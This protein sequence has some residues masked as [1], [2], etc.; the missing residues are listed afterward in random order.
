MF[1][2]VCRVAWF[3]MFAALCSFLTSNKFFCGKHERNYFLK[4]LFRDVG[5][6]QEMV[7]AH[8]APMN[9]GETVSI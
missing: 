9:L 1:K 7:Y 8:Q 3:C 4:Y 5:R 6:E 2:Y